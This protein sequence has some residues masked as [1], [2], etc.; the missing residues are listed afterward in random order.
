M[1]AVMI[2]RYEEVSRMTHSAQEPGSICSS[3]PKE[4]LLRKKM[5]MCYPSRTQHLRR[6]FRKIRTE[7]WSR[8]VIHLGEQKFEPGISRLLRAG[9]QDSTVFNLHGQAIEIKNCSKPKRA[10]TIGMILGA[11][12]VLHLH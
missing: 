2:K 12:R 6:G 8:Q 11:E 1:T 3:P 4:S 7:M 10:V 5:L 9:D